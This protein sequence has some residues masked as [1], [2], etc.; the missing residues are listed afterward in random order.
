M[1]KCSL[2]T[3]DVNLFSPQFWITRCPS[4]WRSVHILPSKIK[5]VLLHSILARIF[6]LS[7]IL[8]NFICAQKHKNGTKNICL[9]FVYT[10]PFLTFC[11]IRFIILFCLSPSFPSSLRHTYTHW[12]GGV[13]SSL[14]HWIHQILSPL[15]NLFPRNENIL[16]CNYSVLWS[17]GQH[18]W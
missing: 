16:L 4:L 7:F 11:F 5:A 13:L 6:F 10:H 9:S 3:N 1:E 14:V 8:N 18:W 15:H 17:I 2:H 12:R